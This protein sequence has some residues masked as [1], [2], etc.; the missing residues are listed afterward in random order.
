[1]IILILTP[2]ASLYVSNTTLRFSNSKRLR[3]QEN[4]YTH[5]EACDNEK[6]QVK[7][8]QQTRYTGQGPGVT[9][10]ELPC[11]LSQ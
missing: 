3:T 1:M 10:H 7:I 5:N 6:T 2:R 9:R 8:S 11:V 4:H